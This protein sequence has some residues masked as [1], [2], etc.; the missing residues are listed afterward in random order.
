MLIR[1]IKRRTSTGILGRPPRERDFQRQYSWK[2]IRCHRTMVFGLTMTAAFSS[3]GIH[4]YS[5]TNSQ[6][7]AVVRRGLAGAWRYSTLS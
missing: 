3:D 5:L 6:R 1:R 4:R 2:P 7:S